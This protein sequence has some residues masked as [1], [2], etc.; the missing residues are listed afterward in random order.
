MAFETRGL[1]NNIDFIQN[2]LKDPSRGVILNVNG[3]AH[4][5]V[6]VRKAVFGDSFWALDPWDGKMRIAKNV[7]GYASFKLK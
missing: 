3:G 2:A 4:W 1:G 7:V 5:V 6:A